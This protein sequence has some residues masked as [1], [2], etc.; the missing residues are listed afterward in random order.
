M[1]RDTAG[2][3]R[4]AL[5]HLRRHFPSSLFR[6]ASDNLAGLVHEFDRGNPGGRDRQ[7]QPRQPPGVAQDD[8]R[9]ALL[10]LADEQARIA[11]PARL[12][13]RLKFITAF[14]G[15]YPV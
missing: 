3:L 7:F 14:L 10:S 8:A 15:A 1:L 5:T 6:D 9:L 12:R 13:Q 2:S 4:R 11:E